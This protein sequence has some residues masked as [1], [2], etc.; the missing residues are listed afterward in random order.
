MALLQIKDKGQKK[1]SSIHTLLVRHKIAK[2]EPHKI[3]PHL[4]CTNNI[5]LAQSYNLFA[6]VISHCTKM[7]F[8]ID[9]TV[10]GLHRTI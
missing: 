1:P 9:N 8:G 3:F 5:T 2:H 10:V 6:L 4:T 7:M